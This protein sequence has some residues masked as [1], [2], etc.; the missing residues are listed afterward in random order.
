M[1]DTAAYSSLYSPTV[2]CSQIVPE[3][4]KER[5]DNLPM[6]SKQTEEMDLKQ[7]KAENK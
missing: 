6:D 3:Y 7:R 1:Q 5:H 4:Q 2:K